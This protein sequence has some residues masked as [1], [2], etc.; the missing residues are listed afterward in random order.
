MDHA[1]HVALIRPAVEGR[2]Q[3]PAGAWADLGSGEGAFTLALA[4]LLGPGGTILSVDLDAGAL[5]VQARAVARRFPAAVAEYRRAD[6]TKP[7]S[8]GAAPASLDGI[9]MANSLHYVAD[10]AAVLGALVALLKPGGRFVLVEYD[11]D[12]GNRWVPYP[13]SFPA[14]EQ[15]SARAGLLG[16]RRVHSVPSR[17]LGRI[18]S[19]ASNAPER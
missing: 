8:L 11:T 16:T 10:Q 4:D 2:P 19:A 7:G 3:A 14:W 15:L 17:F 9:L 6:F 18:Y 5:R 12:T 13:V 1:D